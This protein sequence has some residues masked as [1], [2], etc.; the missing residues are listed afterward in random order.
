MLKTYLIELTLEEL[1]PI[2]GEVSEKA[3]EII[4]KAKQESTYGFDLPVMNEIL[5]NSEKL[6]SLKWTFKQIR[7]C[8]YCDKTYDYHTYPRSG[9]YHNKGDKNHDK[10]KYYYGI[11]FNEGFVTIQGSGDMC[12]ECAS[13][14]NVIHR[15]ID[16]IIDN[17]LK[18]QIQKND[19]RFT[20][21][22]KDDIRTCYE[23]G[24]EMQESKMGRHNTMMGDGTYPSSCPTCGAESL[25]FGKSHK[26]TNKFVMIENPAFGSEI[27]VNELKRV[28]EQYN[29][30]A[31]IKIKVFEIY[32]NPNHYLIWKENQNNHE[33]ASFNIGN[34][35]YR[36]RYGFEKQYQFLV[37]I[38]EKYNYTEKIL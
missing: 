13:K 37:D 24:N 15:L 21:Y 20:K 22:I 7:S 33:I 34:K 8:S 12:S 28:I 10:P 26:S 32:N 6:G 35:I 11:K 36:N 27:L 2:D 31:D 16:Y 18:I 19:Y 25:P 23:C 38:L 5:R 1:L 14:H 4:N 17:D 3:Q 30:D 29:K 9:R